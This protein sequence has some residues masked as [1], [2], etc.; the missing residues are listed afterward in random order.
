MKK[1]KS[2]MVHYDAQ[3]DTLSIVTRAGSEDQFVEIAPGVNVEFNAK[4]DVLGFEM[5]RASRLLRPVVKPL[6]RQLHHVP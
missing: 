5:L 6:Y 1:V 4:G 3:S 2:V